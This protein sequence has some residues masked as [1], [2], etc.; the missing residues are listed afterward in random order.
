MEAA[1]PLGVT[2]GVIASI[3]VLEGLFFID[4]LSGGGTNR[5]IWGT[6]GVVVAV[7]LLNLA[8]GFP[9]ETHRVAFGP[10]W[11]PELVLGFM[12]LAVVAGMVGH[13][14]FHRRG[15]F[16]WN[17]FARPL[18]ASPIVLLPLIGSLQGAALETVQVVSF[19][20]LAYQNG[21][22]WREVLKDARKER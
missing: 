15:G 17:S 16:S 10:G 20:I 4:W 13:Y 18:V 1:M 8:T 2:L 5:L 7:V 22:F 19:V 6:I 14:A 21:F 12:F 3:V 11:P 9:A